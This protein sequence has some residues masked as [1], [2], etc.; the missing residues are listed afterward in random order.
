MAGKKAPYDTLGDTPEEIAARL[1]ELGWLPMEKP[2]WVDEE[3]AEAE[4]EE[5]Y[6]AWE[7]AGR[8]FVEGTGGMLGSLPEGVG[9]GWAWLSGQTPSDTWLGQFGGWVKEGTRMEKVDPKYSGSF[10]AS[11]LP[12]GLGSVLGFALSGAG[13]G[14][15]GAKGM[16]YLPAKVAARTAAIETAVIAGTPALTRTGVS[17]QYLKALKAPINP[18]AATLGEATLS[19][20]AIESI[21]LNAANKFKQVE[22]AKAGRIAV[23]FAGAQVQGA[24]GYHDAINTM[25]QK[26]RLEGR[27]HLTNDELDTAFK[28]Y[29]Y[30]YPGGL[31]E[32]YG[33]E[34]GAAA[35]L[36]RGKLGVG[37]PSNAEISKWGRVRAGAKDRYALQMQKL[38]QNL[39]VVTKGKFSRG[40]SRPLQWG[41]TTVGKPVLREALQESTQSAWLNYTANSIV[42]Y[43]ENRSLWE[44][45]VRSGEVGGAI[46]FIFGMVGMA[47]GVKGRRMKRI[48]ELTDREGKLR[49]AGQDEAADTI[50]AELE[51]L[52][53]EHAK[54][55]DTGPAAENEVDR[56]LNERERAQEAPE[57]A[58]EKLAFGATPHHTYAV[59]LDRE[60][61]KK[62]LD[63]G[64]LEPAIKKQLK[65]YVWDSNK[66]LY[67]VG[68]TNLLPEE[69][70][71]EHLMEAKKAGKGV[72]K[73]GV[74]YVEGV[75]SS[76]AG[77]TAAEAGEVQLAEKLKGE[78][79][80]ILG[81]GPATTTRSDKSKPVT[82]VFGKPAA[83]GRH[84]PTVNQV[85]AAE[86]AGVELSDIELTGKGQVTNTRLQRAIDEKSVPA[87]EE[88]APAGEEAE[89]LAEIEEL[90]EKIK[91]AEAAPAPKKKADEPAPAEVAGSPL[92]VAVSK[93][94]ALVAEAKELGLINEHGEAVASVAVSEAETGKNAG[95]VT[96]PLLKKAIKEAREA[97]AEVKAAP[98]EK[99][100]PTA[101][102]E[103]AVPKSMEG[104]TLAEQEKRVLAE[105]SEK[106]ARETEEAEASRKKISST[107]TGAKEEAD[108]EKKVAEHFAKEEAAEE[109]KAAEEEKAAEEGEVDEYGF[110]AAKEDIITEEGQELAN[111]VGK[112]ALG[113]GKVKFAAFAQEMFRLSGGEAGI[114]PYIA[115]T[116]EHLRAYQD[117]ATKKAMDSASVAKKNWPG[118]RSLLEAEEKIEEA[119]SVEQTEE[120]EEGKPAKK[121]RRRPRRRR[122]LRQHRRRLK[123]LLKGTHAYLALSCQR[124]GW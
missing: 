26:A 112:M 10:L 9:I 11:D 70:T 121:A 77:R 19:K 83:K 64:T 59:E 79:Y 20:K 107:V 115:R 114:V 30:N 119:K 108:L 76:F 14:K 72:H 97:K 47:M 105:S 66:P 85:A 60:E 3:Q 39:D 2:S 28:A 101:A 68:S 122:F 110:P 116:Y 56:D 92:T 86:A 16:S 1:T 51:S 118:V 99:S 22:Q 74:G 67:Y 93:N 106:L 42:K 38:H 90:K 78:G 7:H 45:V 69:R 33:I 18:S 40:L 75:G 31:I 123:S 71:A 6:G 46:G 62:K 84:A 87:E 113:K 58:D 73:Y 23:G 37:V 50:A 24:E 15:L 91:V 13:L 111:T 81:G 80:G 109:P 17:A 89:I 82:K 12:Q 104:E 4:A 35:R 88:A 53:V 21:T 120:E 117:A 8:K 95:K 57:T 49:E 103:T 25:L 100:K 5:G 102:A 65:D 29:W 61:I 32:M 44:G 94:T 55:M 41:L 48:E 34:G 27:E 96:A 43:D 52:K 98:K 124:A 63:A 36:A 54:D